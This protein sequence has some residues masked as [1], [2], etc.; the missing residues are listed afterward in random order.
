MSVE[1]EIRRWGNSYAVILPSAFVK[2][3]QLKERDR[4]LLDVRKPFDATVALGLAK[5][6]LSGQQAK[7]LAR[8]GWG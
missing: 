5:R 2:E 3:R 7:D 6:K 1:A 4:V 8:R